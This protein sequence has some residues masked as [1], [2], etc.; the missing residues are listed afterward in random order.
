MRRHKAAPT[1]FSITWSIKFINKSLTIF[2]SHGGFLA[3]SVLGNRDNPFTVGV[4]VA[5]VTD[6]RYYGEFNIMI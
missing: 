4:A 5:P 6:W 3:S 1:T 2:Q